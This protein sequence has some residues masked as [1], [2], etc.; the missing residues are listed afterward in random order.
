MEK[1]VKFISVSEFCSQ[2]NIQPT[3]FYKLL[4]RHPELAKRMKLNA[5]GERVLDEKALRASKSYIRME[6]KDSIEESNVHHKRHEVTAVAEINALTAKVENLQK[7]VTRLRCENERMKKRL[8][9]RKNK[10]IRGDL[11]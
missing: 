10:E 2:N 6:R 11:L 7:E 4:S 8:N 3:D 9:A 5:K 1:R